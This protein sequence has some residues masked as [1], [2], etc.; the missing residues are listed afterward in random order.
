VGLKLNGAHQFL[1]YAD[2]VNLLRDNMSKAKKKAIPVT[3]SGGL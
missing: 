1:P 3:G 2:D